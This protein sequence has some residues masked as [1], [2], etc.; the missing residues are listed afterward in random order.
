MGVLG[1]HFISTK[2]TWNK[3]VIE[4]MHCSYKYELTK[5][6]TLV[7]S[8]YFLEKKMSLKNAES[9]FWTVVLTLA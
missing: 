2:Q 6:L 3:N 4:V 8:L 1:L 9:T 5:Q 7:A